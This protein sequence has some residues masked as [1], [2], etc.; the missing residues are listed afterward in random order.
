MAPTTES[1]LITRELLKNPRITLRMSG[2]VISTL[3]RR[4]TNPRDEP[5]IIIS[6]LG[7]KSLQ[8]NLEGAIPI[9][10]DLRETENVR[11]N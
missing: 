4:F 5:T 2:R 10:P 1:S 9:D 7:R 8:E 3:F 6:A 11:E